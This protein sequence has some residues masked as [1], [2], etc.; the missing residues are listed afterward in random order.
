[1]SSRPQKRVISVFV[2]A[3]INIAAIC[4]IANLPLTAQK[5]FSLLFL[6][7]VASILFFIPCA[8]ISAELATGWPQRGGV[9]IWV[10]EAL[11]DKA[12]FV[13]IW[14]QWIENVVWY[15]TILS[16]IAATFAYVI[17]PS[18][19]ENKF[20]ILTVILSVYWTVTFLNLLGMKISGWIS[21][22][23][24]MVGTI[25]PGSFIIL[26]GISWLI[27]GRTPEISFTLSSLIPNFNSF[28]NFSILAAV[29]FAF[30]GLEMS[31]VHAQEVENPQKNYP[32]AILLSAI[33]IFVITSFAALSI[34][35][36][37][38]ELNIELASGTIEAFRHF[39]DA[40]N[41]SWAVPVVAVLMVIGSMGMVSTWIVGPSK[42]LLATA[43]HGELPP[44][45][46]KTNKNRMPTHLLILQGS[47][48]TV[49][50]FVFLYMPNISSAY[51]LLLLL[52]SQLYLIM[53]ILMFVSAVILRYKKP[54][55]ERAFRV[56]FKNT[57][58]W[59]AAGMGL[60]ACIFGLVLGFVPP[61]EF[62]H[63]EATFFV[64]F[65]LI[66]IIIFAGVPLII[67]KFRKPTWHIMKDM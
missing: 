31:A 10:K 20:Y 59:I 51:R 38:P 14:L 1:M 5:G 13:A 52:T 48:V 28:E 19:A 6:Y 24:V 32:K 27:L 2:L 12:S 16:F 33:V 67:H 23:C 35:I 61:K 55:V 54:D 25:I 50:A 45:L 64:I 15:P 22:F 3:M 41:L 63:S 44:F 58:I 57:G 36:V 43:Q 39:L 8:L 21:S 37:V 47:I 30:S 65:L 4:N 7:G 26:L 34:A 46:Q 49:L 42:G 66:G 40:Y 29:L 9:Y 53:Y 11:G 17:N 56:P 18:L 62:S 60:L